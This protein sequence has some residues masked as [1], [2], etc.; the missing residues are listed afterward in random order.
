MH[1]VMHHASLN[2]FRDCICCLTFENQLIVVPYWVRRKM[3][4]Q[5]QQKHLRKCNTYWWQWQQ[6][7]PPNL[8]LHGKFHHLINRIYKRPCSEYTERWNPK[9]FPQRLRVR[10]GGLL[11]SLPKP[12]ENNKT[13]ESSSKDKEWKVV[14][15]VLLTVDTIVYVTF[16][17]YQI[18]KIISKV[19]K[20]AWYKAMVKHQLYFYIPVT[21][22]K[23]IKCS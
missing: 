22:K 5:S 15:W 23:E 18:L 8:W 11:P 6:N 7:P 2:L 10:K 13:R 14:I 1:T 12:P 20:A 16:K 21:N 9:S 4:K 17:I 19:S 3:T